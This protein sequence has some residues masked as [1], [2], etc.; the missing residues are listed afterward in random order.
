MLASC[1]LSKTV[2]FVGASEILSA[3]ILL[4]KRSDTAHLNLRNKWTDELKPSLPGFPW[5]DK[6]IKWRCSLIPS[7]RP[8]SS[9]VWSK[10]ANH[11]RGQA[12]PKGAL[13]EDCCVS[14]RKIFNVSI[15]GALPE[16]EVVPLS[17]SGRIWSWMETNLFLCVAR[18]L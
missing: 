13:Q 8:L 15:F 2:P 11:H 7:E 18:L 17:P 1:H 14:Q 9:S 10:V 6:P 5:V 4:Y 16:L 3:A 12:G